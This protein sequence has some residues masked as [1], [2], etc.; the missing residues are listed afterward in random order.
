MG[1]PAIDATSRPS[2]DSQG[3][4]GEVK[5]RLLLGLI[6]PRT[7]NMRGERAISD[8]Y[9]TFS[10]GARNIIARAISRDEF[11]Y[12]G[13]KGK[14]ASNIMGDSRRTGYS[15]HLINYWQFVE[16]IRDENNCTIV[17]NCIKQGVELKKRL[18]VIASEAQ[19]VL[20]RVPDSD[21]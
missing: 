4:E 21:L 17:N 8:I 11:L 2:L 15:T 19:E 9:I 13:R 6:E 1:A 7:Y 12:Q 18:L 16:T 14:E 20:Y 10:P 5:R 3:R